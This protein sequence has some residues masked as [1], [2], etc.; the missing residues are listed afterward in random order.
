MPIIL[1]PSPLSRP[2]IP[3]ETEIG[4]STDESQISP[5]ERSTNTAEDTTSESTEKT[6][7]VRD[8]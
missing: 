2:P 5:P 3:Q 6:S 7:D 4:A 8:V 1:A